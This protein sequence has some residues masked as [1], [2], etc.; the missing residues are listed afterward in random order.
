MV[1]KLQLLVFAS[2]SI[3][4]ALCQQTPDVRYPRHVHLSLGELHDEMVVTWTTFQNA[5]GQVEYSLVGSKNWLSSVA[6][7]RLFV[8]GG[9]KHRQLFIH[10]AHMTSLKSAAKYIYRVGDEDAGW[11]ALFS[12]KTTPAGPE[13]S[14]VL[15]VYGDL[16]NV[17]GRSIGRLQTE[18]EFGTIDSVLH[19]GDFAYNMETDDAAVGDS[20]MDQIEPIAAY[21]PYMT[22]VGNH[23][24][25]YNFSNYRNRFTMPGGD[26]EGLW[27]S[28]DYGRAHIVAVSSEVYFYI[29][30]G[31]D[32]IAKQKLWLQKDFEKA[33]KNREERP[34][35]I[36]VAHR[37]MYCSNSDHDDCT[38]FESFIRYAF[39]D[40]FYE[41]GVDIFI[42]AHEHSYERAWPL[43]DRKICNGSYDHP[44][45]DPTGPIHIVTGSAGMSSDHDPFVPVKPFW[46]AYRT[47]NY[48]YSKLHIDNSTHVLLEWVDDEK[49]G[50]ITDSVWIAKKQ[51]GAGTYT[52][53]LKDLKRH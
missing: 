36:V 4:L 31:L 27:Y 52:C 29:N 25:A 50:E 30:Q 15:A 5:S 43:Y 1:N 2:I 34:W 51:H 32:L 6:E 7:T 45:I 8:D 11:S 19:I 41:A 24:T 35:L 18:A 20:F 9:P 14:P 3:C 42:G 38:F 13:W 40:M 16:G 44:Y 28:Y 33:N 21:V 12:F 23:E 49:N 37:P 26:G 47:T 22:S 48:G 17:N 39:E 10:R 46:S 53:H